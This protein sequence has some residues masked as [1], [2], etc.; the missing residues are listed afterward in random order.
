M[1]IRDSPQESTST[2]RF[3]TSMSAHRILGLYSVPRAVSYTHLDVY[4]RQPLYNVIYKGKQQSSARVLFVKK[5]QPVQ[6]K[7][8][9]IAHRMAAMR[10]CHRRKGAGCHAG[11]FPIQGQRKALQHTIQHAGGA[12]HGPRLHAGHRVGAQHAAGRGAQFNLGKLGSAFTQGIVPGEMC[13]R[14][15]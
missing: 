2:G 3:G 8:F 14:D 4:K 11:R 9:F 13:I 10:Q 1:C 7:V 5:A 6:H 15:R 12:E